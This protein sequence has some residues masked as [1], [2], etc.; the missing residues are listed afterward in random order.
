MLP[1]IYWLS[2]VSLVYVGIV[3][4]WIWHFNFCGFLS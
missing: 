2:A 1:A 4:P 3:L